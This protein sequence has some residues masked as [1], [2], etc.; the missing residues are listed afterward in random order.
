MPTKKLKLT[1]DQLLTEVSNIVKKQNDLLYSTVH[2]VAEP[3]MQRMEQL[4]QR[5][6]Q[7]PPSMEKTK[8]FLQEMKQLMNKHGI[9][10][11]RVDL[12]T[13]PNAPQTQEK[14]FNQ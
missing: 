13:N 3:L 9:K 11:Y 2:S 10:N 5:I 14:N 8:L 6:N 7:K 12:K 1:P 4:E